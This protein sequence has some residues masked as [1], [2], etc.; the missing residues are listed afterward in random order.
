M[1]I[2]GDKIPSLV[3]LFVVVGKGFGQKLITTTMTTTTPWQQCNDNSGND[4]DEDN[5][6]LGA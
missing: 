1:N 5:D 4:Y 3:I 6:L 2:A